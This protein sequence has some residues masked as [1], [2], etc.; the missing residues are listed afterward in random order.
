MLP[1]VTSAIFRLLFSWRNITWQRVDLGWRERVLMLLLSVRHRNL[2]RL[3][4]VCIP[5]GLVAQ[6][7]FSM[8]Y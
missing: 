5:S 6:F 1:T 7:L 4:F 8:F 3:G 2:K